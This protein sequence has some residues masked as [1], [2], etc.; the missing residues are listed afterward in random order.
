MEALFAGVFEKL[1]RGRQTNDEEPI[2]EELLSVERLEQYACA[3]VAEHRVTEKPQ[4]GRALLPHLE[5]NGRQLLAAYRELADAIHNGRTISPAAEW[6]VDNFH[7]VE[8]QLREIREDLPSTFYHELPK[9]RDGALAGYPRIYAAALALV[10][11]TDSHLEPETIKRFISAYQRVMPLTIGELWAVSITLRVV[12]VENLRRLAARTVVERVERE[13]GDELAGKLLKTAEHQPAALMSLLTEQL[14]KRAR[15]APAFVAQLTQRLRE[16]DPVFVPVFNW[17][18]DRLQRDGQNIELITT[19]EHQR[20]AASQMM[21]GNVITSMRLLSTYNWRDFFESISLVD[22]VLG[23]DP[24]QVYWLMDFASRDRYR[25]AIE[26]ISKRT[27]TPETD[28]AKRCVL[29]AAQ[30]QDADPQDIARAHVGYYLV[31]EG[32]VELEKAF[33]YSAPLSERL[34]RAVLRHP[35]LFYLGMLKL[36]TVLIVAALAS[37]AASA[38]AGWLTLL[39]FIILTII[40][41][42]DLAL[43][44]MNWGLT[45][46]LRPRLLSKINTSSG[47]PAEARTM[48]V[49]PTLLTCEETVEELLEK[50]EVSYLANTDEH[51]YFALLGDFSDAHAKHAPDDAAILERAVKGI[52]SLNARHP[53]DNEARFHL[54][55][56][57]RQWNSCELKWMGWERKR[58]KLHEFNRLLRGANDTSFT[59]TSTDASFLSSVRYVLT[60]D[61][62]THLPRDA[63]RWLAG[64]ALHPLNRPQYDRAAGRVVKGY[65]ILQPH[66]SVTLESSSRSRF[67]SI[68][69]GQAGVDAYTTSSD[70]Y[71]DIFAEGN[72]TGKGLYDVDVFETALEG[73]VPDN[74]V[75][76]HDLFEGLYARC[77][78]VTDIE[79]LDEF[80][81]QY[82]SY[83]KRQHRWVRGDWQ[84]AQWIL[85]RV[86]GAQGESLR[87]SLP[88]ISRWKIL[89][90]LRRSLVA[91]SIL[92][93]LLAVWTFVP[94]SPL[95][96]TLFMLFSLAFNVLAPLA[97][98][99]LRFPRRI[100]LKRHLQSV[101][102]DMR[103]NIAQTLLVSTYLAHQAYLKTDAIARTLYRRFISHRHLLEWMTAAQVE[104]DGAQTL[105]T[106]FRFMWPTALLAPGCALLILLTRPEALPVAA[107]F[108]LA[109]TLSPLIMYRV[110]RQRVAESKQLT[111]A[112]ACDMRL[113]ARRTWGFFETLVGEED[114]WLTPDN[115]QEDPRPTVAH[116][117]SPTNIGLLLLSTVAAHDLGYAGT[118]EVV[119]RLERTLDTLDK[120]QKYRGHFFNW[121]NTR[122]LD[123]LVPQYISTVDSGNLA[124]HLLAVKQGCIGLPDIPLLN[125]RTLAGL[126][127]TITVLRD[128]ASRL[129]DAYQHMKADTAQRLKEE[130]AACARAVE[131]V[132]PVTWSAWSELIETL[133]AHACIIENILEGHEIEHGIEQFAEVRCWTNALLRQLKECRRDL[134]LIAPWS[135]SLAGYPSVEIHSP[136]IEAQWQQLLRTLDQV[137]S[138]T[139]MKEVY[140]AALVQ[141]AGLSGEAEKTTAQ[142]TTL[143]PPPALARL[144]ALTSLVEDGATA[145]CELLSGLTRLAQRCEDIFER[146]DFAFLFDE[147]RKLFHLGYNSSSGRA[148]AVHYDLFASESLLASFIAIAKGDVPQEHWFH[149][150]R[151]FTPVNASQALISWSASM[152]EYLMPLLVMRNYEGTLLDQTRKAVVERHIEYGGER[153]VP[154]GISESSFCARDLHMNY[155]YGAFGVPG[156]GLKRGL[157]E[158]LVVAPYATILA[159]MVAPQSALAN[160]EHLSREGALAR[161]GFYESIDYTPERLLQ[162]QRR[163][164]VRV[165]MA[166]HQGM[167]LVALDNVLNNH[168]MR[169]RFHA[170]MRVRATELL[171][172]ERIPRAVPAIRPRAEELLLGRTVRT[173]VGHASGTI[174]TTDLPTPRTQI[175]SNG[176]YAVMVTSAGGGYSQSGEIAV[177]RWREDV[178]RDNYGA[179]YYLRDTGSDA[180]WSA[181]FQP[182]RRRPAFYEATFSEGK[183]EIRR[184]D[185]GIQTHTEIIVAPEDAAEIRRLT[186]TNQSTRVR[187]IE[188][189]SYAEVVLTP[190]AADISHLAFSNLFIEMEFIREDDALLASRRPQS[191]GDAPIWGFHLVRIEGESVGATQYETHRNRFLGRGRTPLNP[192]AM[193]EG[194]ALSNNVDTVLDPVFSLR[195]CV[196][197]QPNQTAS[198][199]FVTGVAP[200]R[201]EALRL[202]RKFRDHVIFEREEREAW[203]RSQA[204]MRQHNT[205]A[206]EAHLFQRLAG[207]MLYSDPSLRPRPQ[208][209]ALNEKSQTALWPYGIGGDLPIVLLRVDDISQ[210]DL[211][212]QMLRS[213][214]YLRMKGLQ[215]ELLILDDQP[216]SYAQTLQDELQLQI[217]TCASQFMQDKRG[218]VFLLR[219]DLMPESDRILFQTVA[220]AV[221]VAGDGTLEEQLLRKP[222]EVEELPGAFVPRAPSRSYPQS[223]VA[224]PE[225]TFFNGLGGFRDGGR[226]YIILLGEGQWTPA[227]W[228]NVIANEHDFGFIVTE[229]GGGYAWSA[230][231]RENRLT[232]WANDAIS[233]QPGEVLYLRDEESGTIWT[234]TPLP[235]REPEPYVIRHGQ[236]YTIFE[237]T[238]HGIVQELQLFVPLDAPVKISV[239]RLRNQ[240]D[241][242][243]HISVTSFNELILGAH[244]GVTAPYI[245]TKANPERGTILARNPHNNEFAHRVAFAAT[246]EQVASMTC[247]CKEFLGRNGSLDTPAA[248]RRA[249]LAGRDGAG[250]DPCAAIQ[251]VCELEPGEEREFVFLLGQGANEEEALDIIARFTRTH[252]PEETFEK[253]QAHWNA[254][255][256]SVEV[257]TPDAAMNTMMNR[258]LLYQTLACRLWA[259]SS[260]YQSGGAYGFR[261]QLQDVMALI[262]SRPYI[263]RAQIVRAAK[264]QF[265]EG[266][267]QH[268]WHRPTGR[269]VR[270]R[271]SDDLLWMPYVAA[272]YIGKTGDSSILDEVAP[273]IEAPL[274]EPE[275]DDSYTQPAISKESASIYEHCART[276]DR[277]LA[278]G[279][280][281][282]PLMGSG[283]WNDGM[284]RI[285]HKGMGESVWVGWFLYNTLDWFAPICD[286]RGD[287]K[288]A[289]TY[290]AHMEKLKIALEEN[291]WDGD[292]YRRAYFDDGTPLGSV[293]NEDCQIDS[294][295]QSWGIISRAADPERALRALAAVEERLIRDHDRLVM[296]FTPPFDKSQLEPGYV[297]GYVPG[298]RENGGQY[299]HAA[300]WTL[301][302]YALVGDGKRAG[303]LFA[304]LNPINHAATP[305]GVCKYQVEPYVVAADVYAVWPHTGRGGWTWYTGSA[306]WMYRAGLE[307]ILGFQLCS[308]SLRIEPCIPPDWREY[309]IDY[310]Y[311]S[312]RYH[313][314]VENPFGVSRGVVSIE[315]DGEPQSTNDIPLVDD[316]ARH[317]VR[318]VLGETTNLIGEESEAELIRE[319]VQNSN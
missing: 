147:D 44:L 66:I 180:V 178:T 58:G 113:I 190:Q 5:E 169:R 179:F 267:V 172:Q 223:P 153:G 57:Q 123:P 108:L 97:T 67:A 205:S 43:N 246:R 126:S 192:N 305:A 227:P 36:L 252:A 230:N 206:E 111:D 269:G 318:V 98:S 233:D 195:R 268:W 163:A 128:G 182:T 284:N 8:D 212:R 248:L 25:H 249:R 72:Y 46:L 259:R 314:E 226:E 164:I 279:S 235:I 115:F 241:R 271:F 209:L 39:V 232:P 144:R 110:S 177:T 309:S 31:D 306:A 99:L 78:L 242:R 174:G 168:A 193:M 236:G 299:T 217:R 79:L 215:F 112:Q 41:A 256:G 287:R 104:Q 130:V 265:R 16:Q 142:P 1:K 298:V 229:S 135:A 9:L 250:I 234:P 173:I 101:S 197:L 283:D 6:L 129:N 85:P 27:R 56:R 77:A 51:L 319:Q 310:R 93:W 272:F 316:G 277:S 18:E 184:S 280:H 114:H 11:H 100:P 63:A 124:G 255:L 116:R 22:P 156:L 261:D 120:L 59:Y 28:V 288:R 208:V 302:A 200:T 285:G 75:L 80:P 14:G 29:L 304:L 191:N 253:V 290:R 240:T 239:L 106:L 211:V 33:A 313:I 138:L 74:T 60:L 132:P 65:G 3:L 102:E 88:L 161:Y 47:L 76:S 295:A 96:W 26:R 308:A 52:E 293:Q 149:L 143:N 311:R 210:L 2:R 282:L 207:R 243:R 81:A 224:L 20:Q 186:L 95:L 262:Y 245:I 202:T 166:H 148:D 82:K 139:Y 270:T 187:E 301:I 141:L 94:G 49:V 89:D 134:R 38:G 145:A 201:E 167:I 152:F 273:F 137:G 291:A 84:I 218:G 300:L 121:Y 158:D 4:R 216:A 103:T 91:Q 68:F 42:S 48:V 165:Y 117:T 204:D 214:E 40:P 69:C 292:W 289:A 105:A 189:T 297:K 155:Q 260:L 203:V 154:W 263:A 12:L 64:V 70:V 176:T 71:Q 303:E 254:I 17:L 54:F 13:E 221:V 247:D 160:I 175:L 264:R 198:L 21:V 196:R 315:L 122:T 183:V 220:R 53:S 150:G 171:L 266:D 213:H 73:R 133:D 312:T 83:A 251:T 281:G 45:H 238:S 159:A 222:S 107:P 125:E 258:W 294:I 37:Y 231:S 162:D 32:V 10:A 50:L 109:W 188:V 274:L 181:G 278:L 225:L 127:D 90:N 237:H 15:L 62:D 307:F 35:T 185:E 61:S 194:R 317:T 7:I 146:M 131:C 151:K 286:L 275:Q 87:N 296:L 34:S 23:Q 24:A 92:V 119:E 86:P 257:Q 118:L 228:A 170:E 244:R 140:D 157:S 276:L 19:L 136:G 30:A 199:M 55:H 219:A